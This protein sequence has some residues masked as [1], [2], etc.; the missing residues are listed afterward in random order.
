MT[1]AERYKLPNG[2]W[3]GK[4]KDKEGNYREHYRWRVRLGGR[5]VMQSTG[6]A[7]LEEA[8]KRAK[9]KYRQ[10]QEERWDDVARGTSLKRTCPTVGDVL[11][12]HAAPPKMA[13]VAT[14]RTRNNTLLRVLRVVHGLPETPGGIASARS[15]PATEINA[16][17]A[18]KYQE[19]RQGGTRNLSD[20]LPGNNGINS[21]LG[22]C[23]DIFGR[24]VWQEKYRDLNLPDCIHGFR[25][26]SRL[27]QLKKRYNPLPQGTLEA[28]ARAAEVLEVES[29][30]VWQVYLAT[31]L[32]GTRNIELLNA[33]GTWLIERDGELWL[34][35]R[36]RDGFALKGK[37]AGRPRKIPLCKRLADLWAPL[38]G[39]QNHLI[40][41]G[42]TA[43]RRHNLCY[44]EINDFLRPYIP[45]AE[46]QKCAYEL[47]KE[48]GAVIYSST[49]GGVEAAAKYL[50][51]TKTSTT[52]D[53]YADYLNDLPTLTE[54]VMLARKIN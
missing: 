42:E 52:E 53:Y 16:T 29:P 22:H 9:L 38:I 41:D 8:V 5:Q 49:T 30:E 24:R 39:Q 28:I 43:T 15:M 25:A 45:A 50:G 32:L 4:I 10:A 27:P 11:D 14:V 46:R 3:V 51:H 6:T 20:P 1:I 44:R 31:R 13:G 40:A 48:V 54:E 36:N 23:R 34:D 12:V 17:L 37:A 21:M 19:I 35:I 47:R 18:E 33:R 26:V 7:I 2:L